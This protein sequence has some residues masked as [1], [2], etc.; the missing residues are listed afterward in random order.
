LKYALSNDARARAVAKDLVR[1]AKEYKIELPL[2]TAQKTTAALFGYANWNGLMSEIGSG[3]GP[4]DHELAPGDLAVRRGVQ[5]EVLVGLGFD[6]PQADRVLALLRPTGRKEGSI[7]AFPR[8]WPI[9]T[10]DDHHPSRFKAVVNRFQGDGYY[11]WNGDYYALEDIMSK[12]AR[13]RPHVSMD[14]E[15][16]TAS[17][18]LEN[19]CEEVDGLSGA[20]GHVVEVSALISDVSGSED[21]SEGWDSMPS[22]PAGLTGYYFHFGNHRFPSPF[23]GVG[24]AGCYVKIYQVNDGG[25]ALPA[26]VEFLFTTSPEFERDLDDS[27]L[28]NSAYVEMRSLLRNVG[29]SFSPFEGET[30]GDALHND[31]GSEHSDEYFE[32]WRPYLDVAI[33]AAWRSLKVYRGRSVP[34]QEALFVDSHQSDFAKLERSRSD[35]ETISKMKEI[36]LESDEFPVRFLGRTPP[37]SDVSYEE[38]RSSPYPRN[39]SGPSNFTNEHVESKL[40]DIDEASSPRSIYFCGKA[41]L[42][43]CDD[44]MPDNVLV[45]NYKL[46]ANANI[47]H[48]AYFAEEDG[49][50]AA[51]RAVL[52][53]GLRASVDFLHGAVIVFAQQNEVELAKEAVR[54]MERDAPS[55]PLSRA[56]RL[57]VTARFGSS[58]EIEQEVAEFVDDLPDV[59]RRILAMKDEPWEWFRVGKYKDEAQMNDHAA[60][61]FGAPFKRLGLTEKIKS[62][63]VS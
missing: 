56:G 4:E 49:L 43:M 17:E 53:S 46:L 27:T 1:L 8:V 45:A 9:Q 52:S 48:G 60:C 38:M 18:A 47:M 13:N 44:L 3:V 10:N 26:I 40:A 19:L 29:V 24:I 35:I 31:N 23:K 54:L 62:R 41:A 12:W 14:L 63:L 21:L 15:A 25:M 51:A 50:I 39:D 58:G 34:A 61:V 36:S 22:D 57:L 28:D 11:G 37:A 5:R 32:S 42:D 20:T 16:C 2:T 6:S 7:Q 55:A 33:E 59:A 30:I